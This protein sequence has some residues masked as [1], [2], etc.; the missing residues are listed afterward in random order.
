M[1]FNRPYIPWSQ[2]TRD[3]RMELVIRSWRLTVPALAILVSIYLMAAPVWLPAPI[4]PQLALL[5]VITWS[6]RRPDLVRVG[7]AFL[8][9]LIQDLWLGG[10]VGVEASLFALIAVVLA[11]QQLVFVT[12]PFRFEWLSVSVIVLVHQLAVWLLGLWLWSGE[13]TLLPLLGQGV[14][15][16]ALYPTIVWIHARLQRKVVDTF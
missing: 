9:G 1:P 3:E 12:R 14:V 13:I 16:V 2:L 10:P 15:T 6:I 11:G 8:L 7:I 4:L 5:G